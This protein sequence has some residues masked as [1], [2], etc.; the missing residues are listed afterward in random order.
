MLKR[1]MRWGLKADYVVSDSW[2]GNKSLIRAALELKLC[3]VL[4][5]KKGKLNHRFSTKDGNKV[6]LNAKQL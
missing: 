1:A 5:M 6:L 4:R 3:A 2:Y